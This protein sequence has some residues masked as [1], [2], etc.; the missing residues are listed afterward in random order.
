M[1]ESFSIS[2]VR[3]FLLIFCAAALHNVAVGESGPIRES[4]GPDQPTSE[5]LDAN[6][7]LRSLFEPDVALP[8]HVTK[9]SGHYSKEDWAAVIDSTWGEGMSVA[10]QSAA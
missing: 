10:D 9:R 7:W 3:L 8:N 6:P 5:Q 4:I 2:S 1:R